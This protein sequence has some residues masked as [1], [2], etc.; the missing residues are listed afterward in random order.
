MKKPK[1]GIVN[2][3]W[4]DDFR[5]MNE[6]MFGEHNTALVEKFTSLETKIKENNT[7]TLK[8]GEIKTVQL[9]DAVGQIYDDVKDVC[10]KVNGIESV[11]QPLMDFT[12]LHRLLKKY[13]LYYLLAFLFGGGVIREIIFMVIGK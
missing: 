5:K 7:V 2:E 9:K 6:E 13:K 8:N 11:I 4:R 3:D 10:K 1:T 12:K